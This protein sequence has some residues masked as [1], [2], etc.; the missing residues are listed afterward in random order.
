MKSLRKYEAGTGA[1]WVKLPLMTLAS[2]TRTLVP[3]QLLAD[4]PGK[5][6]TLGRCYPRGKPGWGS[7]LLVT[8]AP[9]GDNSLRHKPIQTLFIP[10][11]QWDR[12]T[13]T[14]PEQIVRLE[15]GTSPE[16]EARLRRQLRAQLKPQWVQFRPQFQLS[17]CDLTK[18][19]HFSR[20]QI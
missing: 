1:P 11:C 4:A 13:R 20:H 17:E 14:E 10:F 18:V 15:V 12:V 3:I 16:V 5:A 6:V 7:W 19:L 9:T 2:D 8:L